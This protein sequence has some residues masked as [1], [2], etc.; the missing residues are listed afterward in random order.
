MPS[1]VKIGPEILEKKLKIKKFT[2]G[3]QIKSD[4]KSSLKFSAKVSQK[5][6]S[7]FPP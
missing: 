3:R 1:L 4:Q 7:T 6:S 2:D 5:I